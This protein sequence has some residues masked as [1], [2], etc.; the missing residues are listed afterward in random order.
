MSE[1]KMVPVEPT[2]DMLQEAVLHQNAHEDEPSWGGLYRAMIADA[3]PA[4][5]STPVAEVVMQFG[6][7]AIVPLAGAPDLSLGVKLYTHPA[8]AEEP[9][10]PAQVVQFRSVGS[11][12]WYDGHADSLDGG[13][14]YEER[15]LYTH[16]VP[17]EKPSD[18]YGEHLLTIANALRG[19]SPGH[20]AL[21]Q[22]A[23]VVE[24]VYLRAQIE[25][26]GGGR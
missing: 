17:A 7:R 3:P 19:G 15:T 18:Q 22:A 25:Q 8:P 20:W 9:S 10:E 6:Q 16:P 23:V 24:N 11:A 26:I 14:P 21:R 4:P 12:D 2:L 13:G 1:W 5:T